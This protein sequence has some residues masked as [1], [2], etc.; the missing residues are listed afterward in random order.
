MG[1]LPKV[2]C[3]KML[4]YGGTS[5]LSERTRKKA[6]LASPGFFDAC[7]TDGLNDDS[8]ANILGDKIC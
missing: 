3:G 7:F 5:T 8:I 2:Y 6:G 4:S 1:L